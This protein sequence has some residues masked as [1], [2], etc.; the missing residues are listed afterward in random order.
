LPR[1]DAAVDA[2]PLPL[3]LA[4]YALFGAG[5]GLVNPPIAHF[6]AAASAT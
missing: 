2:T 3:L 1:V 4:A 6:V 5:I